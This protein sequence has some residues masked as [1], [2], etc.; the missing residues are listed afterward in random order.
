M[1]FDQAL[2]IPEVLK[3][4]TLKLML[5]PERVRYSLRLKKSDLAGIKKSSG[6]KL[7]AKIGKTDM[8]QSQFIHCLG[9]DEWL[10]IANTK[11]KNKLKKVFAKIEKDYVVS[12][13]DIS[14]R[15]IGFAIMGQNAVSALNV[16]CP[17]DLSLDAFPV[18]KT[19]RTV[20]ESTAIILTRT[21]E[22]DFNIECWRSFAPYLRD[23]FVRIAKDGETL[24][25]K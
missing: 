2:D 19:T 25:P 4:D 9:P 5:M 8:T 24:P 20:F 22:N 12:I 17:L 1:L 10:I 13:T 7:P 3:K 15:N 14:H 16:G 21:S 6:L 23:F 11:E 18:G